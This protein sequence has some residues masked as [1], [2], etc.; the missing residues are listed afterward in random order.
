M[1]I[2]G[3]DN[4]C[5]DLNLLCARMPAEGELVSL[6]DMSL[7]GGGK[8]PNALVAA[9]RLGSQCA[10]IGA[11]GDDRY[12]RACR[13]DLAAH[14]IDV[15][16]LKLR[17]GHTAL[18]VS[19]VAGGKKHYIESCPGYA[20]LGAD[21]MEKA[22]IASA[23][24]LML[25]QL[26]EAALTAAGFA[27]KHGVKVVADADE[28]D[29]R[30]MKHLSSIDVLI[31][32]EY[33]YRAA[34]KGTSDEE[35]LRRLAEKGVETVVVTLGERGSIGLE[36]NNFFRVEAWKAPRVV[37]TTGAGDVFHG[38][39]CHYLCRGEGAE[40][41]ARLAG[42]AAAIKCAALGG[43]AGIPDEAIAEKF[44]NTGLLASE[45]LRERE[46]RY[47]DAAWE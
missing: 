42:A 38:A 43:R 45:A 14:G 28:Y 15:S 46:K 32:S 34:C 6:D 40:Q 24:Y 4:L 25:Y 3:L 37:D 17:P 19:I 22:A 18:C 47:R 10:I 30:T 39:F 20:P 44:R 26:D 13:D 9:A 1:D 11:A 12:G 35:N 41:A 5:M 7:Q 27:R 31:A 16:G 2:I 23:K 8:V 29:A 36:R 21:E 33:F